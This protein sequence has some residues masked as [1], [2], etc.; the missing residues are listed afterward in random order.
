M[1]ARAESP[2]LLS[3]GSSAPPDRWRLPDVRVPDFAGG[4]A[5]RQG[6]WRWL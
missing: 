4:P 2:A 1:A 3:G 6:E 5:R